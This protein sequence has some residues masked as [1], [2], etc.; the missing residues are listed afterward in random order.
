M[1]KRKELGDTLVVDDLPRKRLRFEGGKSN[2]RSLQS[3]SPDVGSNNANG[4]LVTS[5]PKTSE[6]A[7]QLDADAMLE[8]R[9]KQ[10]AEPNGLENA[11]DVV[12][13]TT[14]R[15]ARQQ[16][17]S[18]P[19]AKARARSSELND[20]ESPL[21]IQHDDWNAPAVIAREALARA[22]AHDQDDENDVEED[23]LEDEEEED[24]IVIDSAPSKSTPGKRGRPKGSK[25][26]RSPTP[27]GDIPPEERYFFQ[28]RTGPP[29]VSDN[30]LSS[31]T[32]LTHEEYYER[33]LNNIDHH[34]LEKAHLMKLHLR[35]FP[36]WQF[37]LS[38]AFNL[39]LY[40]YGSKRQLISQFAQW[41]YQRSGNTAKI[42]I[43][44]GYT[45]KSSIRNIVNTIAA[46]LLDEEQ[47]LRLVGQPHEMIDTL[48]S[49]LDENPP[50]SPI[51]VMINS[52]DALPLRRPTSQSA[53][54]RLAS[55]S[56]IQLVA[57]TDLPTFTLL[58]NS[59]LQDQFN[60]VYHDSTTFSPYDAEI[61]VVDEINDL[62][63][64]KGKRTGGKDGIGF[65][66]KSLP[67]NARN[68][69]RVLL[70][71]ILAILTGDVD[72]GLDDPFDLEEATTT[73]LSKHNDDDVGIEYRSLYQKASDEFICSSDMN[74]RFLLKEFHDHQ[75]ITSRRDATGTEVL[76]VPLNKEE[77]EAVLEDLMAS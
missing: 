21:A 10:R 27:E 65:V 52:I 46:T 49:Y 50:D 64:R 39:C 8:L 61:S 66:L 40:G 76:S 14:P 68:L 18:K 73:K 6:L 2:R 60:F 56:M 12:V 22:A 19:S 44:N 33:M 34:K 45:T 3:H 5:S 4:F 28:N 63:G 57:T 77:I 32:F 16:R 29:R 47:E 69:Y 75:I 23:A 13:S 24:T 53:L 41:L 54:A 62:L 20:G 67:E 15:K 31:L 7:Q 74:F 26:R 37:E 48:L 11:S 42:V 9:Q 71:E 51:L 25:N 38:Q 55:H 43:V 1:V 17:T 35:S 59:S 36:Q 30:N 58:W 72:L 70:S